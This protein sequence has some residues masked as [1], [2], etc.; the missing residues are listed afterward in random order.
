MCVCVCV[1]VCVCAC[2][3]RV[4]V[5]GLPSL[6]F[7]LFFYRRA[8]DVG[9]SPPPPL[10]QPTGVPLA[11][12]VA[13]RQ[14]KATEKKTPT[15]TT[16][17]NERK[18]KTRKKRTQRAPSSAESRHAR[19]RHDASFAYFHFRQPAPVRRPAAFRPFSPIDD[20]FGRFELVNFAFRTR[21]Q[22]KT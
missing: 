21:R 11:T 4:S 2:V 22:S 8:V 10:P 20:R 12:S 1:C 5:Y 7:R 17:K 6:I 15:T 16:T 19:P 13:R 9:Q 18:K 14:L 3:Y